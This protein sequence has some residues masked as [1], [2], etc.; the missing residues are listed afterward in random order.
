MSETL[1]KAV[2]VDRVQARIGLTR[3]ESA[4][5]I[6]E[7]LAILSDALVEGE[8][9]KIATFGN[10]LVRDKAARRGRNPQ[11]GE[12]LIIARRRVLV[13]RPSPR[14]RALLNG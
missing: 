6:D 10:F 12:A 9:V 2:L 1:T 3:R 5:L 14:L 11:T 7:V 13:F 4:E 8:K